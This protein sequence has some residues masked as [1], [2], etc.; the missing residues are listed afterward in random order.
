MKSSYFLVNQRKPINQIGV[1][2]KENEY[3]LIL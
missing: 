3:K 1:A 2:L